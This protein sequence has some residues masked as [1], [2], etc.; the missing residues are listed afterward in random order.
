MKV[1]GILPFARFL[2]EQAVRPGDIAVDCTVG[3]GHDTLF[4]AQLVGEEGIIYGF[5]I[6]EQAITQTTNR[7]K[8][9]NV[10]TRCE[11]FLKGHEQVRKVISEQDYPRLKGAIFNLGYLPGG[12]KSVV[13][14][15]TSTLAAVSALLEMMPSGGIIVLVIYHGHEEGKN[16]KNSVLSFVEQIDQ[17]LAHVL[18]YEFI[19]QVNDPP[20]VVAIEKR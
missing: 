17:R 13:T 10:F 8:E 12:D 11:L 5:D 15:A 4:L 6:Q 18:K 1:H 9:H 16:E 20:F 19:N 7:L 3:N 14:Q 2:L